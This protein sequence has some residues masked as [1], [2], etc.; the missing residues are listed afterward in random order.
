MWLYDCEWLLCR[1]SLKYCPSETSQEFHKH[2][3]T[4][5]MDLGKNFWSSWLGFSLNFSH[6]KVFW[7]ANVYPRSPRTNDW[8]LWIYWGYPG[9]LGGSQHFLRRSE[10]MKM[11]MLGRLQQQ[12]HDDA[13]YDDD[14]E[15]HFLDLILL[16][17]TF[18]VVAA[19]G[20]AAANCTILS[21]CCCWTWDH[22][23]F[24]LKRI[25][26]ILSLDA[27][28]I[29]ARIYEIGSMIMRSN[30]RNKI[31]YECRSSRFLD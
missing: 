12:L 18:P 16:L 21:I 4:H 24:F 9:D 30:R 8:L 22:L 14:S 3:F 7:N 17:V 1:I 19:D 13:M 31:L 29:G 15:G 28:C 11:A 20:A 6:Y 23:L 25:T 27:W 10:E 5:L 2:S 26:Q